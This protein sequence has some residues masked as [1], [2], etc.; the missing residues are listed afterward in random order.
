MTFLTMEN[1]K[2]LNKCNLRQKRQSEGKN[3]TQIEII[4]MMINQ[5]TQKDLIK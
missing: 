5:M 4:M 2:L 3:K 1:F